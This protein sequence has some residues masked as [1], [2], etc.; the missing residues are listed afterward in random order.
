MVG[1]SP[2]V[3]TI[4]HPWKQLNIL[5]QTFSSLVIITYSNFKVKKGVEDGML[6]CSHQQKVYKLD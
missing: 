6:K 1:T 3:K 4:G 2:L 5:S